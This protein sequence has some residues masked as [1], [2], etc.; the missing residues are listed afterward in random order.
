MD[1]ESRLRLQRDEGAVREALEAAGGKLHTRHELCEGLDEPDPQGLYW[2]EIQPRDRTRQAFI[3]RIE[4]T[5]YPGRP[6]SVLF[7]DQIGGATGISRAWP[8]APGYR[9]PAD[10]CK[11]F[12]AEGQKLHSE[13]GRGPQAWPTTGNPFL[14]VVENLQDDIDRARGA[15]AA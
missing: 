1:I 3:A 2:A 9:G 13:W 8:Q 6:P 14:Y 5:V 15:R 7:A 11:P 10:I 12:T 4:W